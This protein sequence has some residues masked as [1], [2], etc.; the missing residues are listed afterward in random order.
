MS[1]GVCNRCGYPIAEPA[2]DYVRCGN[3]HPRIADLWDDQMAEAVQRQMQRAQ[4]SAFIDRRDWTDDQWIDD[5][6]RL[7]NEPDGAITSLVNGH[8]MALLRR[9]RPIGNTEGET[10]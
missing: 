9:V 5:A 1:H 2:P 7:M 4:A 8:V 6:E 10:E 3:A